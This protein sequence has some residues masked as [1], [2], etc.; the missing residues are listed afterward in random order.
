MYYGKILDTVRE[1]LLGTVT[2]L[3]IREKQ[4]KKCNLVM[5]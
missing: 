1:V 4:Y 5:M 3:K 2:L